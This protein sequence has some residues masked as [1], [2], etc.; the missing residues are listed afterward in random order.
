MTLQE[1][2]AMQGQRGFFHV[3]A[4]IA[5]ASPSLKL[6]PFR[7]TAFG[8]SRN[9]LWSTGSVAYHRHPQVGTAPQLEH[10]LKY[11][12]EDTCPALSSHVQPVHML[13][14]FFVLVSHCFYPFCGCSY[15]VSN[16]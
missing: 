14:D 2:E 3:N 13:S 15:L 8:K 1:T 7:G 6:R 4:C 16:L 10:A 12:A 9:L 5:K 11:Y